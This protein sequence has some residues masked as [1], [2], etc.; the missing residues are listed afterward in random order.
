MGYSNGQ[1]VYSATDVAAVIPFLTVLNRQLR[2][3]GETQKHPQITSDNHLLLINLLVM[4]G[5][6]YMFQHYTAILREHS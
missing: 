6:S 3:F 5:G 1:A 2:S 4:Y